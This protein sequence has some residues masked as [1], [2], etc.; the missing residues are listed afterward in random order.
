[1]LSQ[2]P[3]VV[4][5]GISR[6]QPRLPATELQPQPW[7]FSPRYGYTPV[8]DARPWTDLGSAFGRIVCPRTPC[9]AFPPSK[10][11]VRNLGTVEGICHY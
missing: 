7:R 10:V 4:R 9:L 11:S 3:T 6:T 5:Q 1:M 8:G 2:F